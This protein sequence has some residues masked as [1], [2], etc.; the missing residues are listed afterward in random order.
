MEVYQGSGTI[1]H[2]ACHYLVTILCGRA[3]PLEGGAL[4][5]RGGVRGGPVRVTPGAVAVTVVQGGAWGRKYCLN[6]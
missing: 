1:G 5:A 2:V 4:V 3:G 6:A